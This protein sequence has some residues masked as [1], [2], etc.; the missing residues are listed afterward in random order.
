MALLWVH[1]PAQP[2]R[3]AWSGR[4]T[5]MDFDRAFH[6]VAG[7]GRVYYGSSADFAVHALDGSIGR[8]LWRFRTDGPVRL[9]PALWGDRVFAVSDDGMLHCLSAADGKLIW[10]HRGGPDPGLVLGNGRVISR[11]PARGG[12]VLADD[13]VY[14]GAGIWPSE[15]VFLYAL[16]AGS[17]EV[18]W[19]NETSGWLEL[20]QPHPGA[21]ARS[22][23]SAQG[24]LVVSGDYLLVPTG[25]AVPAVFRRGD[26]K[27][28]YFRLQSMGHSG[29]ADIVAAGNVYAN[30]NRLFD[31]AS[32]DPLGGGMPAATV[33]VTPEHIV[34]A[35]GNQLRAVDRKKPWTSRAGK[36]RRGK[37]IMRRVLSEPVWEMTSP[38][39]VQAVMVA[40]DSLILG[41]QDR[42]SVLGMPSGDV[43]FEAEVDGG[44][45]GLSVAEGR[46]FV[47]TDTGRIHCFGIGNG[48]RSGASP[49]TVGTGRSDTDALAARLV[50]EILGKPDFVAAGFGVDLGC[51]DGGLLSEFVRRTQLYMVGIEADESKV[52]AARER[53]A[54]EGVYGSRAVVFRADPKQTPLPERFANLVVSWRAATGGGAVVSAAEVERLQHPYLGLAASGLPGALQIR[55]GGGLPGSGVWTHQYGDPANTNCSRDERVRGPL[56]IQWFADLGFL[57]PSRHGRGPA[58][59]YLGGRLFLEGMDG[60]LCVDAFN[61]Q[62]LWEYPL[63]GILKAYDADH[64]MGASGTGS[65]FC[66]SEQGVFV[67]TGDRCLRLDLASG[68]LLKEFAPPEDPDGSPGRWGFV[69]CDRGQLFGSLANKKHIV[70]WVWRPGDMSTQ[71]T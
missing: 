13:V 60:V 4:D 39:P 42:I 31:L 5:R 29:G 15:G 71:F 2:P 50:D 8:E 27:F 25:R 58:P 64:I 55:P 7:N 1:V 45:R 53:L 70:R 6:T 21:N 23:I 10:Q 57:M 24:S 47:S 36:D 18:L 12:P 9:P 20:P 52:E 69:A 44:A 26:G 32:G 33:A 59:L 38:H 35:K 63:P 54:R 28:L 16:A 56:G 41:G 3:P 67:S 11:W 34:Y 43:R 66:V 46:L 17:G 48:G 62:R 30:G 49:A 68:V 51:G 14:Y 65:N 22:G 19:S 40:G 37:D 61:G